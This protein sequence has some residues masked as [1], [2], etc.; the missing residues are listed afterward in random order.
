MS[1][2]SNN[3]PGPEARRELVLDA[4]ERV[5][6]EKGYAGVTSRTVGK[7]AGMAAPH[8]HY[9][10]PTL[11]DLF[12]ALLRRGLE[13][14]SERFLE[15][16]ESP[17]PLHAVWAMYLD[18]RGTSLTGELV[19]LSNHRPAVREALA[20]IA[21]AFNALQVSRIGSVLEQYGV[22][23]ERFPPDLV[24]LALGGISRSIIRG[25]AMT[26]SRSHRHSIAAVER[27]IDEIEPKRRKRKRASPVRSTV[28]ES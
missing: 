19:A 28:D 18:R 17:E 13:R 26:S 20:D 22:D 27:L 5:M 3:R 25:E 12:I 10:F 1:P 23:T 6:F 2:S 16:I 11:D 15:A 21:D 14:S 8:I 7:A 9:Y 24:V 4:A